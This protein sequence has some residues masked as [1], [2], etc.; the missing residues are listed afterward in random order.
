[1]PFSRAQAKQCS[2]WSY[3][4]KAII[5]AL[6][7]LYS[8]L[9]NTSLLGPAVYIGIFIQDFEVDQTAASGLISYPNLSFGFGAL[10][11][12][13]LFIKIGRRPVLILSMLLYCGGLLGC[14]LSNSYGSLMACRVIHTL[15]SG[16]CEVIPIQLVNDIFFIHERGK[17][18]GWYTGKSILTAAGRRSR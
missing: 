8:F 9:A 18:L 2:Q 15:G 10:L 7:S 1:M 3:T 5:L 13:P 6:V 4:K 11:L 17:K 14:A 12:V 16:I